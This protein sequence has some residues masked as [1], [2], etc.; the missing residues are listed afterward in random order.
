MMLKRRN[1]SERNFKALNEMLRGVRPGEIAV[2]DWDNTCAFNDIGEALLRRMTFDLA[3]RIDAKN[4][5]AMIPDRINGIGHVLIR[6]KPFSL[7][8]M[9]EAIFSAYEELKQ[10]PPFAGKKSI[11]IAYR[12]FTSGLLALNRSLEDTPGIGCEFAYPWVNTLFQGLSPVEFDRLA[13][14]VIME[15]L[16]N[17]IGHRSMI[18]PLGRWRYSW[19]RGIRVYQEMTDLAACWQKRG[20]EVVVSSASNRRLVEMI[21]SL[22]GFPCREVIGMELAMAGGRFADTLKPGLCP[23]LGPGKVANIRKRLGSEPALV[24]GDSSNDYEMLTSFPST[25]LRLVVDRCQKGKIALLARRARRGESGY[26]AQEIDSRRGE[27][28]KAGSG[29]HLF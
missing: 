1:W 16:Q 22:T 10:A 17:S 24:A 6:K 13:A 27:F 18:D 28:G 8:K 21:I 7:A 26:L 19:T 9:K 5:A 12:V 3:F 20:G 25:R 14:P 15:E 23:N 4:M 11:D 2:F 29:P